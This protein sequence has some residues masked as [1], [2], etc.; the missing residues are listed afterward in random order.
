[1]S[2][3]A[4]TPEGFLQRNF[5]LQGKTALI[6]GATGAFGAVAAAALAGA[7]A[8]LVLAGGNAQVLARLAGELQAAGT[9]CVA[10]PARPASVQACEAMVDAAQSFGGLDIL[11]AASG[12]NVAKP[13]EQMSPEEFDT[14]MDA[15]VR[16]SWLICRAAGT[17]MKAQG[18]GG[19]IILVSSARSQAG[20]ANYSAYCPS[21]AAIDLL[22]KAL[23]CEWGAAGINVNCIA[24]TVFR[25]ELTSW[26]YDA[27]GPGAAVRQKVLER[28]P[29]G[30]LGEP[31]DFAGA[32]VMLASAASNFMT[33][34]T[35]RLDGGFTAT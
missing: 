6:T 24:P 14:V 19:K 15:N 10:V 9:P 7:G 22:A 12:T 35:L 4:S 20:L 27:Q 17:R 26:L 25:S 32:I 28:I 16:Q 2:G 30:R 23:A 33:G 3:T 5:G 31:E 1:M 29:L 18:R 21:K 11:V 8:R 13:I 34:H